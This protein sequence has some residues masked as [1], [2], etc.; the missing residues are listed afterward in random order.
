MAV[1]DPQSVTIGADTI[2]LPRTGQAVDSGVFTSSDGNTRLTIQHQSTKG[3]RFRRVI[4]LDHS[5]VAADPF[6]TTV[7]A[8]YSET[9]YMVVDVPAVGFTQAQELDLYKG[10]AT[11]LS[12]STYAL[13]TK[14]L[15]GES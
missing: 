7:N 3:G 11:M 1:S 2:S 15:G 4:K 13:A 5:I 10:L 14:F 8:K 12:A 9:V 6:V